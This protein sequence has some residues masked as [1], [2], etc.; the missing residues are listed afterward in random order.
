MI[1]LTLL[2]DN[3]PNITLYA[4]FEASTTRKS[5][6]ILIIDGHVPII[7]LNFTMPSIV[8]CLLKNPIKFPLWGF[9]FA[10]LTFML[11]IKALDKTST[12]LLGPEDLS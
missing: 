12:K 10:L 9:R 1:T 3:L 8:T 5:T 2:S 11:T 7:T 6:S 4:L